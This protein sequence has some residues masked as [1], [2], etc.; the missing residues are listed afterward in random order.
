M[1]EIRPVEDRAEL[2]VVFDL[3][4][5]EMEERLKRATI[6]FRDLDAHF[7]ADS[8][9]MLV[10]V[11]DG[12]RVGGVL[13]FRND[14]GWATLRMIAVV[15]AFRHRRIGRRLLERVEVEAWALGVE[16]IGLGTDGDPVGFYFH[17][18]YTPNLLFQWVY[19]PDR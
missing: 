1:V 12:R 15:E 6:R 4:G 18:G 13:C 2:R 9:L 19:D 17:L 11:A 16:A 10:A 7:P 5:G 3:L 8:L 14:D